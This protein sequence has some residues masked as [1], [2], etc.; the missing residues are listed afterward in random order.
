MPERERRSLVGDTS[1]LLA[2]VYIGVRDGIGISSEIARVAVAASL[3]LVGVALVIAAALSDSYLHRGIETGAD[4]PVVVQ[5]TG[6]E[7][8]TNIDLTRF[9]VGE[10][11]AVARAVRDSGFSYVRQPFSWRQIEPRQGVYEWE[12]YDTI[13]S[14]LA[15]QR[16]AVIAVARDSPEWARPDGAGQSIDAPPRDPAAFGT[17]VQAL[18]DRYGEQVPFVQLWEAPNDPAHWGGRVAGANDFIPLLAAGFNGANS[19]FPGV[20]VLLSELAPA[21]SAVGARSDLQFIEDLYES[22]AEGFFDTVAIRLEGGETSPEDRRV[23]PGQMNFSRAVLFRELMVHAGD[24]S[25][26]IWATSFGWATSSTLTAEE[27]AAFT[28]Q[29]LARSRREWPWMGLMIHMAFIAELGDP[30]APYAMVDAD[31][32]ATPLYYRLTDDE[33]LDR[34]QVANTG[35]VPT[36]AGSIG[37]VGSWRNQHLEGRTFKTIS[38]AQSAASIS[39]HGTGLIAFLRFGPE[40]GN[41]R[42]TV[43]GTPVPG[44]V[45]TDGLAWDLSAFRTADI[46]LTLVSGL[47]DEPHRL[48]ITLASEGQ[49]TL[50]GFVV[51]RESA[52]VWPVVLLLGAAAITLFVGMRSLLYLV[53]MRAGQLQGRAGVDLWPQLPLLPDWRPSRRL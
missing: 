33:T 4:F 1:R 22:E 8:A 43:D 30:S 25:T 13:V 5:P 18:T 36:D 27:Q 23:A 21:P 52:F 12:T 31:G 42:I 7:P 28:V 20:T 45:G 53:A 46:P 2:Q 16:I 49:L 35:F 6:G 17:F 50:G 14:E 15:A 41:V 24:R 19:G 44:G 10:R 38:Q 34:D 40:S 37:Y 3:L 26:A 39:F 11:A 32:R 29:G 51:V 47:D 48:T 9:P